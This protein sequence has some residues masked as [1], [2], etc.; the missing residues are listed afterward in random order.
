MQTASGAF[1][2]AVTNS[3][4]LIEHQLTIAFPAGSSSFQDVTRC[5]VSCELDRAITT[6]LPDGT[7]LISGFPSAQLTVVLSGMLNQNPGIPLNESQSIFWLCNPNDATSPMF[8]QDIIGLP[9]VWEEGLWDG[10]AAAEL[11]TEFTGVIDSIQLSNGVVTLTCLD[12]ATLIRNQA[13]LPPV[14]TP[15]PY[16][17]GLTGEYALDYLLRHSSPFACY[18]WPQQ[19]PGCLLAVGMRSSIW[20]EV[21]SLVTRSEPY[22]FGTGLYGTALVNTSDSSGEFALIYNLA[23]PITSA[24]SVWI[25]GFVGQGVALWVQADFLGFGYP[26]QYVQIYYGASGIEFSTDTPSGQVT[27]T[28]SVSTTGTHYI[29]CEVHWT[30]GSTAVTGTLYFDSTTHAISL[31]AADVRSVNPMGLGAVEVDSSFTGSSV[32]GFQVTAES[33]GTPNNSFSP[34]AVMDPSLNPLTALPDV[35]GQTAWQV[36]QDIAAA[37]AGIAGFDELGIFRFKNRNTLAAVTSSR[38]ITSTASLMSL[39]TLVQSSLIATHVQVPVNAVLIQPLNTVWNSP[40]PVA[41]PPGIVTVFATTTSPVVNVPAADS[42]YLP[43]VGATAGLS[44]WRGCTTADGTGAIVNKGI[45]FTVTQLS[46]TSLKITVTNTN[47]YVVYLVNSTFEAS[48]YVGVPVLL[49]GGQAITSSTG[50]NLSGTVN[51]MRGTLFADAQWPPGAAA[52]NPNYG[53]ILLQLTANGWVQDLPTAQLL[54]NHLLSDLFRARPL[55]RNMATVNDPR[56]QLADRVTI[57]DPDVSQFN[58]DALLMGIQTQLD[59]GTRKQ[60]IDARA[61]SRPGA[62]LLGVAGASELGVTTYL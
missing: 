21:G 59:S 1:V 42:G 40:T 38:A 33:A 54:A 48:A 14:I 35:A 12:N 20:P 55:I 57:V 37:E 18:T 23:S 2:A 22:A 24:Q 25:E 3:D 46:A 17:S 58:G 15:A 16:N 52:D 43:S 34:T 7:T 62:W 26:P 27:Q 61:W 56:T 49:V 29:A 39:D 5:L 10:D 13:T 51:T 28:W 41:V 30:P 44:Y 9:I 4:Q 36:I 60:T 53:E 45:T 47:S 8:R 32:E 19:R 11:I 50:Q 6:T 31:T